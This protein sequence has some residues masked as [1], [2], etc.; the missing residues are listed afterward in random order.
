MPSP[1][2][3]PR[4]RSLPTAPPPALDRVLGLA[5][6]RRR[7][8][9]GAAGAAT[10]AAVVGAVLALGPASSPATLHTVTPA[11]TPTPTSRPAP[12]ATPASV[13]RHV[14][15]ARVRARAAASRAA[16]RYAAQHPQ[17]VGV[18]APTTTQTHKTTTSATG[19]VTTA[20]IVGPRHRMTA[21]DP[22]RACDGSGPTAA[23]GWCSY[24]V[25]ATSGTAGRSVR[26][27][28][29]VCRLPGQAT[30]VLVGNGKQ[31]DFDSGVGAYPSSWRWSHG[32]TFARGRTSISVPA[33]SC[34]EWYVTWQ[35]VDNAGRPLSPGSYYL[36][37][38]P[39]M[40]PPGSTS[41]AA[42]N[43]TTFTVH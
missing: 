40:T 21:Y 12:H 24:Y 14:H 43:P 42:Y 32:R 38:T 16:A 27:A 5:R 22:T 41:A 33:G 20:A 1:E 13:S 26:L 6:R 35:V 31:A 18:V 25:G 3:L 7:R 37:A 34:V 28:T 8:Q 17:S 39:L 23:T 30:G 19:P 10:V 9:M 2:L 15:V 36:D 4:G 29:A 11:V